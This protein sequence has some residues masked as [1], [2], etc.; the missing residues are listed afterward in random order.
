MEL[1]PAEIAELARAFLYELEAIRMEIR[2][3]S[4]Q[5]GGSKPGR[6]R[7]D[8][9]NEKARA[10][11]HAKPTGPIGEPGKSEGS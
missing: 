6:E 8:W 1:M 3:A 9:L 10:L 7:A 4:I 5:P 2:A 11:L